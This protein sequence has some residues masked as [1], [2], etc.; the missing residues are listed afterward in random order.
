MGTYKADFQ[1]AM[2]DKLHWA[3]SGCG[4]K[5]LDKRQGTQRTVRIYHTHRLSL[6]LF[7]WGPHGKHMRT[8][9][10]THEVHMMFKSGGHMNKPPVY[11]T[12]WGLC[13]FDSQSQRSK[14]TQ[15]KHQ[16]QLTQTHL[17]CSWYHEIK[18]ALAYDSQRPICQEA[19]PSSRHFSQM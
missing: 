16:Q 1:I 7:P 10:K 11:L 14:N 6:L 5:I 9:W 4:N 18:W 19:C 13:W 17:W 8:S 15:Q 12:G 2:T 3:L